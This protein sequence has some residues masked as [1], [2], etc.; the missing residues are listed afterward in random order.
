MH[1]G[2]PRPGRKWARLAIGYI[3]GHIGGFRRPLSPGGKNRVEI[4]Q[5]SAVGGHPRISAAHD[6]LAEPCAADQPN[7]RASVAAARSA[8]ILQTTLLSVVTHTGGIIVPDMC[9]TVDGGASAGLGVSN[10]SQRLSGTQPAARASPDTSHPT[11]WWPGKVATAVLPK[12]VTG[13]GRGKIPWTSPGKRSV[14]P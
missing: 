5:A 14:S 6:Q 10:P 4:I 1:P 9:N 8:T 11:P 13:I 2:D 12:S 3:R 7:A